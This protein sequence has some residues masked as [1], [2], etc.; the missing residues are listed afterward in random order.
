MFSIEIDFTWIS[1]LAWSFTESLASGT[2]HPTNEDFDMDYS[3][4]IFFP[5]VYLSVATD[6]I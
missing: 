2:S 3:G 1:R 5:F 4:I 6:Y